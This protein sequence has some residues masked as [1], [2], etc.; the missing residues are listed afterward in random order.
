MFRSDVSDLTRL[1]FA[2]KSALR[3][4]NTKLCSLLEIMKLSSYLALNPGGSNAGQVN[5]FVFSRVQLH[6]NG[7]CIHN[8]HHLH[9]RGNTNIQE[10]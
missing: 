6:N 9:S 5:C 3:L 1:T 7:I 4:K 8:L 2:E 10:E